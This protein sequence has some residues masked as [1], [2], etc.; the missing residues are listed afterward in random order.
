MMIMPF[1]VMSVEQLKE[2]CR[3]ELERVEHENSRNTAIVAD[4]KQ[5]FSQVP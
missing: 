4:Y 3:R 5:V 1:L 2:L